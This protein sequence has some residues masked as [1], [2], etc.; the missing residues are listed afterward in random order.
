MAI[1]VF[2]N[3]ALVLTVDETVFARLL[4]TQARLTRATGIE[5]SPYGTSVLAHEH[6][7]LWAPAIL[8]LSTSGELSAGERQIARRL[9]EVLEDA[10]QRRTNL[11]FEGD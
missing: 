6:C 8:E 9:A 10:R 3:G 2:V 4:P 11:L 7:G 5:V 1:D